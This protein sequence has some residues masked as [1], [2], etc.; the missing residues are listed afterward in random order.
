MAAKDIQ[1]LI[2][3]IEADEERQLTKQEK[4]E[5]INK[6]IKATEEFHKEILQEIP[7]PAHHVIDKAYHE[8]I[9]ELQ[10]LLNQIERG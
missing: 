1:D 2:K 6:A 4:T 3:E 10:E 8:R 7:T 9:S 5:L